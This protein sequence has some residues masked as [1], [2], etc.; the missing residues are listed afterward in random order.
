M[1]GQTNGADALAE[2]RIDE[3]ADAA[4]ETSSSTVEGVFKEFIERPDIAIV[5]INQHARPRA[6]ADSTDRRRSPT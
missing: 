3:S 2:S 4:P 5:L 1:R 6:F